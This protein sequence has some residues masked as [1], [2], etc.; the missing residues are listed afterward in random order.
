[1]TFRHLPRIQ[2]ED[3]SGSSG[4]G[5]GGSEAIA[6]ASVARD[7]GSTSIPTAGWTEIVASLASTSTHFVINDTGGQVMELA[8]GGVG[9]EE[10]II[11]VPPGGFGTAIAL[12]IP[13]GSRISVRAV[14]ADATAGYFLA[15]FFL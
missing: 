1:M 7:L 8:L 4:G 12:T 11:N 6:G 13:S 10:K 9:S 3:V 2:T 14:D 5:V 15:D